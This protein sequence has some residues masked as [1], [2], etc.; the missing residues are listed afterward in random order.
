MGSL[1]DRALGTKTYIS[2]QRYKAAK[3]TNCIRTRK[4]P[5]V[6]RTADSF[7]LS[8]R[9]GF[10][11]QTNK[12]TQWTKINDPLFLGKSESVNSNNAKVRGPVRNNRLPWNIGLQI[13]LHGFDVPTEFTNP[14][15]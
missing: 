2:K 6:H 4:I 9:G 3:H 7:D 1:F 5:R 12:L 13:G 11:G 8:G 14:E 15:N 10:N